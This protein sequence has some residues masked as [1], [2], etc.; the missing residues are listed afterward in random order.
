MKIDDISQ[1]ISQINNLG[2]TTN[3]RAEEESKTE[4]GFE[5]AAQPGQPG[6]RVDFSKASIEFNRAA[7]M[8]DRVPEERAEKIEALNKK[9]MN[10]TYDVDAAKIAEGI[11][12]DTLTNKM[13]P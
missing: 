11:I 1:N 4:K 10:D 5:K 9:I 12:N 6:A 2:T 7:E 13:E 3:K 8:M